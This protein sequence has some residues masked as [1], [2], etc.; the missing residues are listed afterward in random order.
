MTLQVLLWII[1]IAIPLLHALGLLS[2]LRAIMDT[3]TSQ[4]AVAWVISLVTFPY[5]ALPLYWV[6]GRRKFLGYE[7][8]LKSHRFRKFVHRT[9]IV[10]NM[11]A[12]HADMTASDHERFLV[13]EHLTPLRFVRGN[14]VDLL[15]DGKDTFDAVFAAI[16]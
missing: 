9:H 1:G 12:F 11:K 8:T 14:R 7:Q 10:E 16:D 3:R 6:F 13:F 2:A 5:L 4:G 15:V